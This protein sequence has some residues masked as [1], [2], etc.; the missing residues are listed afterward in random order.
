MDE[1]HTQIVT[2]EKCPCGIWMTP[3]LID[4]TMDAEGPQW[5]VAWSCPNLFTTGHREAVQRA[6]N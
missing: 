4:V 2:S 1:R 6:S 5:A 3:A